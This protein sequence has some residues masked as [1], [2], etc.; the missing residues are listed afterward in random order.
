MMRVMF[1]GWM[2]RKKRPHLCG[3]GYDVGHVGN[4]FVYS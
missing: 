3:V 4:G 1:W 2:T